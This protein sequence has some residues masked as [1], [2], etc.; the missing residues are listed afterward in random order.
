MGVV[1][2][3]G[4]NANEEFLAGLVEAV[5][6]ETLVHV[7]LRLVQPNT[8]GRPDAFIWRHLGALQHR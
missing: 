3:T 4:W 5:A 1:E 2:F 8:G 6:L 7:Y